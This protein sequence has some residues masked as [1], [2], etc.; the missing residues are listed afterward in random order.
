VL[1]ILAEESGLDLAKLRKAGPP[2]PPIMPGP[3][4]DVAEGSIG[5]L[6]PEPA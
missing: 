5:P 6:V 4:P 1:Q 3:T 2:K